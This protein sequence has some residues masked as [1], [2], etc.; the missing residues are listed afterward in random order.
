MYRSHYCGSLNAEHVDHEVLV[1][2]WVN[3]YRKMGSLVFI[4]LRDYTG[5]IQL[6]IA[7]ENLLSL[8][9][10]L[11]NEFVVNV[12]GTVRRRPAEMINPNMSTG[13]IEI[14]VKEL[15]ILSKAQT[16]PFEIFEVDKGEA[17][18]DLRL[19]YRYLDLRRDKMQKNLRFRAKMT[20]YIR[21]YMESRNYLSVETPLLTAS[22]PEGARDFLVP[23]RLYPGKFYALPQAPQQFK[24]LLMV[25][26]CDKYYQIAPCFRDE[27][28]RA[29]RSPG[30]FY[31]LDVESSFKTK[32]EFFQEMEPMF[33]EL[34]EKVAGKKVWKKPFPRITFEEA[35]NRWG[36][37]KPDLRFDME[38]KDITDL[39]KATT[40]SVFQNAETVRALVID[41]ADQFSRSDIE[42]ELTSLA[43]KH[44]A[45]GL[46][47]LK[48]Q[49]GAWS[50]SITKF[51]TEEQL[52]Q[53]LDLT[54]A[55]KNSLI[56]MVADNFLPAV[57]ALGAIRFLM[58]KRLNL[59]DPD[60]LAWAWIVDFP[61]YEYDEDKGTWD[62]GHNPFSMPR[63]GLDALT[64]EN[65]GNVIG[66]Q[67]DL[68]S[69]GYELA[70]G[71][72]RNYDPE[73]LYKA[74]ELVGYDRSVVD[75]KFGHMIDAFKFGAPPHCGF[76]PGI[77]RLTMVLMNEDN[78]RE[79]VAFPKNS[80]AI[81]MLTGAPSEVDQNQLDDLHISINK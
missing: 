3:K 4:D 78:I 75:R 58:G 63:G 8:A 59:V 24:Q 16:P 43:K 57:K 39:A 38:I 41:G 7:D 54:G 6:N 48:Y 33:I 68:I 70:S 49:A 36:S 10:E 51:F 14:D 61:M 71:A 53:L 20:S 34:T 32:E 47:W 22:S 46:A 1:A 74:F 44:H 81:E 77:E 9:N 67:Y 40:F 50:G 11:R 65:I 25:A 73:I 18:E 52:N 2:G 29:D 35:M 27:D 19:K 17:N 55:S 62:F 69:N 15:T 56:L 72:L 37:D 5:L 30:E 79:V 21:Q 60:V 66:E 31:Q 45:H 12:R 76:A 80:K 23:S 64:K 26:G 28:P 42:G 13:E